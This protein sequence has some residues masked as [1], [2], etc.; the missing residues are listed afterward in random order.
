M[1]Q[2]TIRRIFWKSLLSQPCKLQVVQKVTVLTVMCFEPT[3][4]STFVLKI[5]FTNNSLTSA[6]IS[7]LQVSEFQAFF[8]VDPVESSSF[9]MVM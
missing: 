8:L 3:N 2:T 4:F 6:L 9:L 5:L 1:L 7:K